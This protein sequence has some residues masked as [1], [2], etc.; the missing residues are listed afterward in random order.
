MRDDTVRRCLWPL[1]I[2]ENT[3]PRE[4]GVVGVAT[5]QTKTGVYKRPVLKICPLEE[6]TFNEITQGGG[7]G[8]GAVLKKVT[9]KMEDE[10]DYYRTVI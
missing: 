6:Q 3:Y 4:Y 7:G 10:I 2:I 9:Q 8:G 1:G 5:L